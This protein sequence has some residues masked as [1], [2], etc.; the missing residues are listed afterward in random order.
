[1]CQIQDGQEKCFCPSGYVGDG[2][3]TE[4]VLSDLNEGFLNLERNLIE[5]ERAL[6]ATT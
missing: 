6:G 4:W 1:M 3:R 5:P 2:K